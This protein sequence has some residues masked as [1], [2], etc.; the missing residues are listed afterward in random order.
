MRPSPHLPLLGALA[1]A[2]FA[3]LL[4]ACGGSTHAAGT[5]QA[6]SLSQPSLT[7]YARCMRANG[8]PTFPDPVPGEGIPKGEVPV[9]NPRFASASSAC[10]NLMPAGGLGP[11]TTT[12]QTR[13]QVAAAIA[14][15]RCLRGHRFPRFPD[16]T[17]SGQLT[18][19][20]I[21]AA[22]ID[23][24]QPAIV[25]AA[26]ACAPVTHGLITPAKVADFIAGR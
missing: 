4:T 5:A 15:A 24:H 2:V 17:T 26:D 19:Q 8:L 16:P 3:L 21:A 20:M 9:G 11:E 13:S 25:R 10:A 1:A 22:G 12:Q 23:L 7:A 18:H 6:G 14:F